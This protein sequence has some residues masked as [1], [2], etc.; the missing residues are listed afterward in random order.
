MAAWAV[1]MQALAGMGVHSALSDPFC[2]A[3]VVVL[4]TDLLIVGSI[5]WQVVVTQLTL[6]DADTSS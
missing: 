1:V 3:C 2:S 6:L 4:G 5:I